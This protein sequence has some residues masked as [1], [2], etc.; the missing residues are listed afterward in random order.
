MLP[1][2]NFDIRKFFT[3][4]IDEIELLRLTY[5]SNSLSEPFKFRRKAFENKDILVKFEQRAF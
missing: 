2:S 5:N 4:A 3:K 1:G